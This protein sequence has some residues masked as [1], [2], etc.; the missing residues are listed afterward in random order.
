V[1]A[2]FPLFAV[3]RGVDMG[4][5][6]ACR[7]T[8]QTARPVAACGWVQRAAIPS[9]TT[10]AGSIG[11]IDCRVCAREASIGHVPQVAS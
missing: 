10:F 4:R 6:H 2:R 11:Q 7:D 5:V 8:A 3:V 1:T 9:T